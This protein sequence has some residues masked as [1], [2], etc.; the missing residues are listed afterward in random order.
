MKLTRR[1]ILVIAAVL[2]FLCLAITVASPPKTPGTPTNTPGPIATRAPTATTAPRPT[3]TIAWRLTL[4]AYN[5]L[6]DGMSYAD[7][8]RIIGKEGTEQ[9]RSS[10]AGYVT[11]LYMWQSSDG[12]SNMNAM[13]QNDKLITRAQFGLK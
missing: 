11:V 1:T 9:S 2:I 5:R 8:V 7:A 4:A 3:P 12:L 13:F 6:T 10:M